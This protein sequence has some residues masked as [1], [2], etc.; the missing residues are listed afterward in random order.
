MIYALI[1]LLGLVLVLG[2]VAFLINHFGIGEPWRTAALAI[3][4]V[5]LILAVLAIFFPIPLLSWR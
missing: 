3:L 2:L 1:Q 4:A 5:I